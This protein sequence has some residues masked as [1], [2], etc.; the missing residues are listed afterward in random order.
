MRLAFD[1][2]TDGLLEDLT[3]IHSLVMVDVTTGR[4]WSCTDHPGFSSPSGYEVVSIKDGLAL[5]GQ[6]D[7]IIGHNIIKFDIP[8]IQKVY[9]FWTVPRQKVTDTLILSR[10]IWPEIRDNDFAL[11]KQHT[12]KVKVQAERLIKQRLEA[13]AQAEAEYELAKEQ[14]KEWAK[15]HRKRLRQLDKGQIDL[16]E[17]NAQKEADPEVPHPGKLE[18]A[19]TDNAA[20]FKEVMDR[21][22]P[23]RLIGSH[24][25]EAWGY[26]LGEWKGD[27]AKEMA[28]QGLDP[29]ASWNVPMQEYCEQDV[30][31][32]MKL[33]QLQ[34]SKSYS[35]RAI[36]I[37]RDFAWIIAE[38]ERNGFPFDVSKA[39][40]LQAKL[41]KE[42]AALYDELQKAFPPITET[43]TFTP[44]A[45]NARM[46]YVKGKPVKMTKEIVFNPGS[47]DHIAKWLKQ[48]Y[49]WQPEEYTEQGK[50]KVDEAVLKK[51][52]YPEADMLARY[53]LIDKRLGML[54]GKGGKGLIPAARKGRGRIHGSVVTNGAVTRRC[55]HNS[56]NM[57]QIPAV[58]VEYGREFRELLGADSDAWVLLGWD[59]SGL[60]LRCF[61]HYMARYDGGAYTEVVLDGDIHWVH[62]QALAGGKLDGQTYDPHNEEHAYWRNKVAKRFIYAFLYGAGPETIG[63]IMVPQGSSDEKKKAG[64]KLINTF[65]KRVPALAR[66]KKDLK[67]V[68]AKRN[69]HVMGIDGGL[70]K[71]RSDHAALNTLLQSAGAI[72]VKLATIIY[73]DKLVAMGLRNGVD[74]M[75]VAHVHD[76]VQ[77]LVRKGL[78]EQVG[79]AAVEAMREAGEAL[80]FLCPLDGEWKAGAN[81]AETH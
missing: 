70:L 25:L 31:V 61:A 42:Q 17:F 79:K 60:E 75:L 35:P 72:A 18:L 49:G 58:T 4:G 45:N 63:E 67:V 48:K 9:P 30:V 28:K 14:H 6:A 46:G 41:M 20:V 36:E 57:A 55:T 59:A 47:R 73:Y 66:L 78:E 53:F 62:A 11:R 21:Y 12:P 34:E 23:G 33:L 22:F 13:N 8:A 5:L 24:G 68:I 76:E 27:Y 43:W 64:R 29:W 54:E 39:E 1:I 71:V 32:T 38:M 44:K 65:L 80:G 37:E 50:P 10:L 74:F 26:R 2:E 15:R 77:T 19:E 7:E 3:T 16:D 56:P 51:L 52:D 69:M 40:A 81:W